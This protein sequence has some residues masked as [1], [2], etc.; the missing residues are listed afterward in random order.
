MRTIIQFH[1]CAFANLSDRLYRISTEKPGNYCIDGDDFD[2]VRPLNPAPL[3]A[4]TQPVALRAADVASSSRRWPDLHG[5][6]RLLD[7]KSVGTITVALITRSGPVCRPRLRAPTRWSLGMAANRFA[8]E[9]G[10]GT[11]EQLLVQW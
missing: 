5:S 4:T 3:G 1:K 11:L 2:R 7:C 8:R 10:Q 9:L 6:E